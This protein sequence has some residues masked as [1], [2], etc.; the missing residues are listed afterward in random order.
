MRFYSEYTY[1]RLPQSYVESP[2][3]FSRV[4]ANDLQ[5]LDVSSTVLQYVDDLLICS[6]SKAQCAQDSVS[7]LMALEKGAHKVSKNKL[8]FCQTQ[9]EYLGRQLCGTK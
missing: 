7:A 8:Q 1:T 3:I 9:V 5:H 6:T 4:L 2:S